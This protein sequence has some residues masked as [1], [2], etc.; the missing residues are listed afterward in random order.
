MRETFL[1]LLVFTSGLCHAQVKHDY[2][3]IMGYA[4]SDIDLNFGISQ[5]TFKTKAAYLT[6]FVV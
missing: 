6:A 4:G 2:N 5:L 3:W 1:I